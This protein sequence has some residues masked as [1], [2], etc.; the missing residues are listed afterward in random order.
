M[1]ITNRKPTIEHGN[2]Y[3]Y[4]VGDIFRGA[5]SVTVTRDA[6]GTKCDQCCFWKTN[7]CSKVSCHTKVD[8]NGV[9]SDIDVVWIKVNKPKSKD[10]G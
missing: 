6:W 10:N 4:E 2:V 1:N 5:K 7:N 8:K 3:V 9:S